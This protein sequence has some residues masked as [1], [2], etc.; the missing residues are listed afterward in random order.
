MR[1]PALALPLAGLCALA[2]PRSGLADAA[3][4]EAAAWQK[5]MLIA[6]SSTD[7]DEIGAAIDLMLADRQGDRKQASILFNSPLYVGDLAAR[8]RDRPISRLVKTS[9]HGF[10]VVTPSRVDAVVQQI[11][12]RHERMG[13]R[14]FQRAADQAEVEARLGPA[15]QSAIT[16]FVFSSPGWRGV[17]EVF[18]PPRD[19]L[20]IQRQGSRADI[21][22]RCPPGAQPPPR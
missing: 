1:R 13:G 17:V 9:S 2:L 16:L 18:H 12:V 3:A 5:F 7:R 22:M 20:V 6:Q 21:Q 4:D 8:A 15:D 11:S 14:S 19:V 10:A